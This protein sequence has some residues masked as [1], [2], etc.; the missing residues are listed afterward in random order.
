MSEEEQLA[1]L[2]FT[3][4]VSEEEQ[5]ARALALVLPSLERGSLVAVILRMKLDNWEAVLAAEQFVHGRNKDQKV[6]NLVLQE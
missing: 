5:L 4:G 6:I 2:L 3:D 1:M